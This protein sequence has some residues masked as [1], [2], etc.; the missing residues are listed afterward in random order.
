MQINNKQEFDAAC[1]RLETLWSTRPGDADFEERTMLVTAITAYEKSNFPPLAPPTPEEAARFRREQESLHD[2]AAAIRLIGA[3]L[4][5]HDFQHLIRS[6]CP[7]YEYYPEADV[8]IPWLQEYPNAS[9]EDVTTKLHDIYCH[10]FDPDDVGPAE[11]Y[12]VAAQE[13]L[14]AWRTREAS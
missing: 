2:H 11:R 3:I 6:G 10:M 4:G 13:I 5:R 8:L 9:V 1:A 14:D 7:E 12:R